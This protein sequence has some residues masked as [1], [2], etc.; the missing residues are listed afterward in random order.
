MLRASS[1]IVPLFRFMLR[2][3]QIVI[4]N[5]RSTSARIQGP[6]SRPLLA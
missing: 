5:G 4:P 1:L 6:H 2:Y 3:E